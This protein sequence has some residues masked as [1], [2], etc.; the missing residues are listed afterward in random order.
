MPAPGEKAI[1]VWD[2]AADKVVR[3]LDAAPLEPRS[4]AISRDGRWLAAAVLSH[5]LSMEPSVSRK[6]VW[7]LAT[8]EELGG[9]FVGPEAKVSGRRVYRGWS[10]GLHRQHRRRREGLGP[11]DR[12]TANPGPPGGN[13]SGSG[14]VARRE[15]DRLDRY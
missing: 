1:L 13:V 11:S 5:A 14:R 8:G 7:D 12:E 10:G 15:A 6:K 3:R 4:V 9:Q 2:P